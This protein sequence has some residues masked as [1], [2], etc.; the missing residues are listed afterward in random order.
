MTHDLQTERLILKPLQLED[1]AQIQLLFPQ[2]EIVKFLN[3]NVPWPFPADGAFAYY[4]DVALPAIERGEEWHWTL[5][6]RESPAQIIGAISLV[7]DGNTNR[8]FWIAPDW[9]GRGLMTEAVIAANDY[10]FDALGF[11]VL[12]SP[13]AVLNVTSRRISEKTGMRLIATEESDYVCGRLPTEL[14]EITAEE[15]RAKRALVRAA[16]ERSKEVWAGRRRS[17]D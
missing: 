12:R 17:A 10:W 9:Q 6:L 15:W 8:G 5:R 13:K 16:H 3:A 2:W 14:W 4:R 11:S 1:A 7:R